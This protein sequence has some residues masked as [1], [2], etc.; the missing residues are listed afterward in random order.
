MGNVVFFNGTDSSHPI[1]GDDHWV[2][3]GTSAGT[4]P[5]GGARNAGVVGA[6]AIGVAPTSI[7]PLGGGVLFNGANSKFRG[8]VWFSNGTATGTY[9]I[10]GTNSSGLVGVPKGGLFATNITVFGD[11]ALFINQNV[12]D[13]NGLW[14]TDGTASG[15]FELGGPGNKG[16]PG[17]L[18]SGLVPEDLTS[19]GNKIIL[20]PTTPTTF[21]AYG[22]RTEQ[23]AGRKKSAA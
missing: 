12:N 20:S 16:I 4:F 22:S 1:A 14:V 19:A 21:V 7:T 15:T 13:I 2:S 18:F 10:G 3:D 8:G 5:V 9:E 6:G 17:Q 11:K 23:P